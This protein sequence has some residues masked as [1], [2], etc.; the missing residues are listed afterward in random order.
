[1]PLDFKGEPLLIL[2]TG[3]NDTLEKYAG[4]ISVGPFGCMQT[5]FAEA[6]TIPEMKVENK[7]QIKKAIDPDY[8]LSQVFNKKMNIPFLPIETDGNVYPQVIEARIESFTLQAERVAMLM[9]KS[10]NGKSKL[11]NK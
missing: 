10:L 7:L 11:Q 2:G 6:V 9:H 3:I 4:I 1:V 5:R 8:K